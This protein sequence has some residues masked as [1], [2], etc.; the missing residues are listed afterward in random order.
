[1]SARG[2]LRTFIIIFPLIGSLSFAQTH[3]GGLGGFFS[4]WWGSALLD[5]KSING[6][7]LWIDASDATTI[8]VDAGMLT[9]VS[10]GGQSV[11]RIKDKSDMLNH[12]K[13]TSGNPIYTTGVLN[14]RSALSFAANAWMD[15]VSNQIVHSRNISIFAAYMFRSNKI[16]SALLLTS[17]G[18][19]GF[20]ITD[21]D[22]GSGG[23][24][25]RTYSRAVAYIASSE[26][27][28]G[29]NIVY[30]FTYT[31]NGPLGLA[32]INSIQSTI[33][34]S[35]ANVNTSGGGY[36][37]GSIDSS[38]ATFAGNMWLYEILIYSNTLSSTDMAKVENYLKAKWRIY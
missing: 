18:T 16:D 9:N 20:G 11:S 13:A 31:T 36:V 3:Q 27:F 24:A 26:T 38:Q 14:N 8:F 37:I 5:P 34:T 15:S 1:V 25:K 19:T 29:T 32:Y 2:I 22:S 30:S 10:A 6:L 4:A 33:I 7:T 23:S 21:R 12:A 17:E 28:N 35:N